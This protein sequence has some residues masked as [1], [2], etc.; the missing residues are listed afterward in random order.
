MEQQK[1]VSLGG[2]TIVEQGSYNLI[3][4]VNDGKFQIT[5]LILKAESGSKRVWRIQELSEKEV[6]FQIEKFS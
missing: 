2:D 5:H 4:D 1:E 3:A 6:S